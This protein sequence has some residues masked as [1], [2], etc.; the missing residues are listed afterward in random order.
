MDAGGV[1]SGRMDGWM[2]ILPAG[3]QLMKVNWWVLNTQLL[4]MV[5]SITRTPGLP[6]TSP[7]CSQRSMALVSPPKH[8][9]GSKNPPR[10]LSTRE[11]G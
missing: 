10:T 6:G 9:R 8:G 5:F 2:M 11:P 7:T 3:G 4:I 1:D